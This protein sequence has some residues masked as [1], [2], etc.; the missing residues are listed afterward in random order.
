MHHQPIIFLDFDDVICLN[1]HFGGYDAKRAL[2]VESKSNSNNQFIW[3]RL[4]DIK[5]KENLF[6]MHSVWMPIY[7]ISSSWRLLFEKQ[8]ILVILENCGLGFVAQNLHKEWSTP[9]IHQKGLRSAEIGTWLRQHPELRDSWVILDDANS[10][11]DLRHSLLDLRFIVLCQEGIGLQTME[12]EKMLQA[13]R[14]R[15]EQ[16]KI[17]SR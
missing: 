16:H 13:L 6:Q 10:G 8:E 5:A 11:K 15:S 2:D 12:T 17:N 9:K 3:D 4:F 1:T 7:V 14:I